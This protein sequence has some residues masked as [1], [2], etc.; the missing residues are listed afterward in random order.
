MNVFKKVRIDRLFFYCFAIVIVLILVCTIFVSYR[1]SSKELAS[2]TSQ[3]QQRLLD[4]LNSEI[5]VRLKMIE[6]IS[7]SVSRDNKLMSLLKESDEPYEEYRRTKEVEQMLANFTYSI[8]MIQA[9]TLYMEDPFQEEVIEYIQFRSFQNAEQQ[10]WYESL[11]YS[12][13][14]WSGEHDIQSFEGTV[15]VLS[16]SRKIINRDDEL[17]GILTVHVKAEVIRSILSGHSPQADRFMLN[18]SGEHLLSVGNLAELSDWTQWVDGFNDQSGVFRRSSGNDDWLIVYSK[19]SDSEWTLV[20]LTPWSQITSGSMKTTIGIF[21]IGIIA[22]LLS[23]FLTLWL[24]KQFTRPIKQLVSAM[25]HYN[26]KGSQNIDLPEDYKNEF[27][28]L[29]SGYRKQI[30]RIEQ[31]YVSLQERHERQRRAELEALQ[32][33]IN[34]HFLY[35]SLDQLNWIAIAAGQL[36]ISQILEL[37]GKMFR[38]TL[39]N[40]EIFITIQ[41]ELTLT[42]SY[43]GIQKLRLGDGITY[44]ITSEDDLLQLYIP[45]MTLQPFVENSIMHG[46]RSRTDGRIEVLVASKGD[47]IEI[48]VEDNGEGLDVVQKSSKRHHIGGYGTRNVRERLVAYFGERCRVELMQREGGGAVAVIELPK[49][50]KKMKDES[51]L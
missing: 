12:D 3:Y 34:P 30:Q 31:L 14:V 24:S 40:G 9:I 35:N 33:N 43:L 6:Q 28:Y 23:L 29:F 47:M 20:E 16:F 27:G 37:M 48:R 10:P 45:K 51:S 15:P 36:K 7:L 4:E 21:L 41:E 42:E 26:I 13:F 8:P 44:R 2:T 49:L 46:F 19:V 17:V 1:I 25:N 38:L 5:A 11:Q 18:F 39:S 22:L 32:A 50:Y